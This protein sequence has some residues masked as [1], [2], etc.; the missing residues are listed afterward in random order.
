MGTHCVYLMS[1]TKVR[2]KVSLD[3]Q[4]PVT[5][6][7]SPPIVALT[8]CRGVSDVGAQTVRPCGR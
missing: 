3:V 5:Y 1:E 7:A 6:P 8:S 4:L 2:V